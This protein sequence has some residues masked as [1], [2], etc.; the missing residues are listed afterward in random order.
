M[1]KAFKKVGTHDGRFH[2]DEV[3]ATAI[4]KQIYEI[5]LVRTRN[6]DTLDKLDIVY[7]VG[8]G[9]FDHHDLEKIY[10]EDGIPYAASGLIWKEFGHEV[11]KSLAP[12]LEG[13]E[14]DDLFKYVDR[15]LIKGIDALDNGMRPNS[16]IR[17]MSIAALISDFNPP[18][19]NKGQV[20]KAFEQAVELASKVLYNTIIQ[21]K[22]V[23][24]AKEIVHAAF[25]KRN[26]TKILVLDEP[27]PYAESLKEIDKNKE[28]LLVIYPRDNEYALQTVRGQGGKDIISL[29]KEWAGREG[30]QLVEVTGVEDA[31]FCHSGLFIAIAKSKEGALKLAELALNSVVRITSKTLFRYSPKFKRKLSKRGFYED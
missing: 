25:E 8:R 9:K 3:M 24:E 27:C 17:V 26:Y 23:I 6:Q 29:P 18:W 20:D 5:E 7:D 30:L 4:L 19:N 31:V 12:K 14:V 22:S 13:L 10:R 1:A 15:I 21:R 2:A 16:N 11:I 28:V